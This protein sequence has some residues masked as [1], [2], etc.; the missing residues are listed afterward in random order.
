MEG[1]KEKYI[2]IRKILIYKK[3][4]KKKKKKIK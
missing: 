2:R 4:K 1:R 3:K